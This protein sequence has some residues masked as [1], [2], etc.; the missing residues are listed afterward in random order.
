LINFI[1]F[2][3]NALQRIKK[4]WRRFRMKARKEVYQESMRV[5]EEMKEKPK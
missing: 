2:G 1:V 4:K 5:K 3:K